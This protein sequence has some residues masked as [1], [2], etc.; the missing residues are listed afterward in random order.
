MKHN[1]DAK[2]TPGPWIVKEQDGTLNAVWSAKM[3]ICTAY[4]CRYQD[5]T[6]KPDIEQAEA[7]ARL[8]A[9]APE[10]LEVSKTALRLWDTNGNLAGVFSVLRD[11][12]AKVEGRA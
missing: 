10:L 4:K 12:I 9:S 8:I 1:M 3:Y 6:N 11:I 5:A 2:Y 7:N